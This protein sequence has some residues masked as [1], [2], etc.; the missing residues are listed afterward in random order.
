[1]A[2][3]VTACYYRATLTSY[4]NHVQV[5]GLEVGVRGAGAGLDGRAI[6]ALCVLGA[7]HILF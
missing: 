6:G 3:I 2:D 5:S 4:S 7:V 1:M